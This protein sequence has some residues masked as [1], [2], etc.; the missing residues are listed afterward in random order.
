MNTP[1]P[2]TPTE[3][4]P[5][6]VN[7]V[8]LP[9]S[10]GEQERTLPERGTRL[11]LVTGEYRIA[12]LIRGVLYDTERSTL[13]ASVTSIDA[14]NGLNLR[15]LYRTESGHWFVVHFNWWNRLFVSSDEF[16]WPLP[17]EVVLGIAMSLVPDKDCLRFLLDWY[18][19]NLIPRYDD[20][21]RAWAERVLSAEDQEAARA[22]IASLP[23]QS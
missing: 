17:D 13:V 16:L 14:A 4:P 9:A 6:I 21:A 8:Y 5:P 23:P 10:T 20:A 3:F 1:N 19:A 2:S 12:E 15:R 7:D 11:N 22:S 18:A